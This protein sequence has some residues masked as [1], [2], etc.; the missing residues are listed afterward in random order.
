MCDKVK[1]QELDSATQELIKSVYKG[2]TYARFGDTG[3]LLPASYKDDA[4]QNRHMTVRPD[5]VWLASYPRSGTHWTLELIW[6][7]MNDIDFDASLKTPLH[8]KGVN[9]ESKHSPSRE[10]L[11]RIAVFY[12]ESINGPSPRLI[13]THIPFSLLPPH[14]L[15]TAKVVYIARDPRDVAVSYYH[16]HRL[17]YIYSSDFKTFWNLFLNNFLRFTPYFPHVKEAWALRHHP[18]MLFIF[19][20]D[21]KKDLPSCIR[22]LADFLSKEVTDEQMVKL[23]EHLDIE[24][25]RK[26]ESINPQWVNNIN[27]AAE[28]FVRKGISGGWREYFDEDMATQAQRWVD[29]NL[30]GSDLRFPAHTV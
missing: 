24:N 28:G 13:Y 8:K 1:V 17:L 2:Q 4:D 6:L 23:C 15:D 29:D 19:Y 16:L 11:Q 20:E 5:D 22:R 10:Y 3:Y 21:M 30:A 14:L 18:N 7:L 26:N 25:F 27:N 9:L 12:E